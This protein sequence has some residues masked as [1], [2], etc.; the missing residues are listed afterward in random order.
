[1]I[2]LIEI[3]HVLLLMF[4]G[5]ALVDIYYQRKSAKTNAAKLEF[6][7]AMRDVRPVK[8]NLNNYDDLEFF[9]ISDISDIQ[10]PVLVVR[11]DLDEHGNPTDEAPEVGVYSAYDLNFNENEWDVFAQVNWDAAR[12]AVDTLMIE[13][14]GG[15]GKHGFSNCD[16][17]LYYCGGSPRCCP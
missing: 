10:G 7:K 2:D 15:C 1:M 11:F 9:P 16:D 3:G 6:F 8:I 17:G 4:L 12:D 14:S 5:A 13:C